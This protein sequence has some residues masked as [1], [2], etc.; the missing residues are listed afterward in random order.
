MS[1]FHGAAAAL[2]LCTTSDPADR[3]DP[4]GNVVQMCKDCKEVLEPVVRARAAAELTEHD[5]EQ[6]RRHGREAKVFKPELLSPQHWQL[7]PW[8]TAQDL[9]QLMHY[10]FL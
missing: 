3:F 5:A 6:A 7:D 1:A 2:E 4:S 8:R 10:L 9:R